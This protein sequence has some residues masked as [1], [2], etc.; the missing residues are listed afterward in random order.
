MQETRKNFGPETIVAS[1]L[2]LKK[3]KSVYAFGLSVYEYSCSDKYS[4]NILKLVYVI[5]IY[6]RV[7]RFES[8]VQR[9]YGSCT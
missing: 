3:F 7:F 8:G 6:Y 1:F 4:F 5:Q 2:H 9:T